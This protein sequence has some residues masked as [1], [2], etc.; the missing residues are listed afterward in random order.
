[1]FIDAT[2]EEETACPDRIHLFFKPSGKICGIRT[3]GPEG[4]EQSRLRP[5]LEV[6]D[7]VVSRRV[8]LTLCSKDNG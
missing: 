2:P 7:W 6:S 1:M 3:E 8:V 5:L 4:L